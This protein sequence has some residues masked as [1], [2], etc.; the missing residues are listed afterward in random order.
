MENEPQTA[1]VVTRLSPEAESLA[2]AVDKVEVE[3]VRLE[4]ELGW[5][6]A[7]NAMLRNRA[8]ELEVNIAL[9]RATRDVLEAENARLRSD[10]EASEK[11][12]KDLGTEID[13]LREEN[14]RLA[15]ILEALAH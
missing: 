1:E 10:E 14:A 8:E 11:L 7:R 15:V 3:N 13:Q 5:A 9:L 12:V 2:E 4:M 6:W